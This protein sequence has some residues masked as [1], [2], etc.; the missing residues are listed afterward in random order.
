MLVVVSDSNRGGMLSPQR[1]DPSG[2][3]RKAPGI[4]PK[5]IKRNKYSVTEERVL[6]LLLLIGIYA[7]MDEITHSL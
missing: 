7:A 3:A 5:S 4:L 6:F 2:R 1:A